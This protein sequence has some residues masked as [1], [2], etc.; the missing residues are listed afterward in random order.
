LRELLAMVAGRRK[1]AWN[2]TAHLLAK[3]HNLQQISE[4]GLLRPLDFHP[5]RDDEEEA[6]EPPQREKGSV[7]ALATLLVG[8]PPPNP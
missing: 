4:E 6:P 8:T 3:M 5:Y 2:H 7:A 1:E